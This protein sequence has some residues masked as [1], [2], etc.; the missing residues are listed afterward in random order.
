MR[1]N[2]KSGEYEIINP[3]GIADVLSTQCTCISFTC[4]CLVR[5]AYI[6]DF[7]R[8]IVFCFFGAY[9]TYIGDVYVTLLI[10]DKVYARTC[11]ACS[12]VVI[13]HWC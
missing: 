1:V 13:G 10:Y 12:C 4:M 2:D 11:H 8:K 5:G 6:D 7:M 9:G 3:F